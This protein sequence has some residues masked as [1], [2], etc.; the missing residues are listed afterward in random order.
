MQKHERVSVGMAHFHERVFD[1]LLHF[2]GRVCA[3]SPSFRHQ[4]LG[5]A[6]SL[7]LVKMPSLVGGTCVVRLSDEVPVATDAPRENCPETRFAAKKTPELAAPV[8]RTARQG[9]WREARAG[10]KARRLR[11]ACSIAQVWRL[12]LGS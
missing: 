2:H 5:M 11:Q 10:E 12:V 6:D 7:V 9:G 1:R 3:R 4:P 8:P